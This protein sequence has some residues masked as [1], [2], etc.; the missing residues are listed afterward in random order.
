MNKFDKKRKVIWGHV[1]SKGKNEGDPFEF[2]SLSSAIHSKNRPERS[3][4][5]VRL[6]N[7]ANLS[8]KMY[9][10]NEFSEFIG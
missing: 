10:W 6:K 1:E 7:R 4:D 5:L 8:L 3:P 2:E 9:H